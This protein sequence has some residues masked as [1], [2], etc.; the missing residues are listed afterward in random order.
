MKI[1]IS[2]LLL[3]ILFNMFSR[4]KCFPF[5]CFLNQREGLT[6]AP[7]PCPGFDSCADAENSAIKARAA[8]QAANITIQDAKAIRHTPG[9]T[10]IVTCVSP[11]R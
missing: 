10:P 9:K 7:P 5:M 1:F 4:R 3:I 11:S 6:A 8:N 2:A